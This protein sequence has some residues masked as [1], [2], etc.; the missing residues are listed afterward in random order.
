[1]ERD[2]HQDVAIDKDQLE[3]DLRNPRCELS[4]LNVGEKSAQRERQY[5]VVSKLRRR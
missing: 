2:H 5:I 1:M 3:N 4:A